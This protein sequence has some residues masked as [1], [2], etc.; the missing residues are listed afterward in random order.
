MEL[1]IKTLQVCTF[2]T[3]TSFYMTYCTSGKLS[4]V[5]YILTIITVLKFYMNTHL[6]LLKKI[7]DY[8]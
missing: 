7:R 4:V 1:F 8:I 3:N 6:Y 5:K 2:I